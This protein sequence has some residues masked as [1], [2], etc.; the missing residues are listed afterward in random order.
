M[1]APIASKNTP[2][3]LN[4]SLS[5]S[6]FLLGTTA[7]TLTY[8]GITLVTSTTRLAL[9]GT[10]WAGDFLVG[11]I[12]GPWSQTVYRIG[13][14]ITQPILD[15][16]AQLATLGTSALVGASA[17]GL[18]FL[19]KNLNAALV[20]KPPATNMSATSPILI[21]LDGNIGAGKST[22]L[23]AIQ[24]KLPQIT[25]VQEPV[26]DWVTLKNNEG[27]NLL[28]LFYGDIARWGYTF[29]NCAILTRL[30]HTMEILQGWKAEP[31]KLPVIITERSVLTDRFV[32]AEML[33][34]EGKIDDLEWS[35][36]LKWYNYFAASLPV[37][38][39]IHLTTSATTSKERIAIRGRSGEE[40][41]PLEYLES[42]HAQHN[43]WIENLNLPVLNVS[44][45]PGTSQDETLD[46]IRTWVEGI[47]GSTTAGA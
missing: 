38:G 17:G 13:R 21:S 41:I 15:S 18:A 6:P 10:L 24:K 14:G 31:G 32:F 5:G 40:N 22:L 7:A 9:Q 25:V 35:L 43:H 27:K 36:Y 16:T 44:T 4:M 28:E 12:G 11:V 46:V 26:A 47:C 1:H 23:E 34:R 8:A 20:R 39:V 37:K 3:V 45:E 33:H 30:M 19:G 2:A 42:L 29:Q